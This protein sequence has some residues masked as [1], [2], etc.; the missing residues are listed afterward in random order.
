MVSSADRALNVYRAEN[1]AFA[2]RVMG[3]VVDRSIDKARVAREEA[4]ADR[5]QR[6][7][8][9]QRAAAREAEDRRRREELEASDARRAVERLR[10]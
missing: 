8:L 3:E 7:A 6:E 5:A 2:A 9:E 4:A 10:G 1:A